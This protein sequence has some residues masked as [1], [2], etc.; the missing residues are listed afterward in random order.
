VSARDSDTHEEG[1]IISEGEDLG[2]VEADLKDL[3]TVK[4]LKFMSASF[5]FGE[6]K[7]TT[8]LIQE[9]EAVGY[10]PAGD[11]RAPLDEQVP[12]P[13]PD[14]VVVFRDF[15][16]CGLRF[17]CDPMLVDI[18][19]KFSV[20]IHQ[21]SPN[22]FL[23]LSKFFWIMR[24][25]RCNF[26]ADVFARLFEMVIEPRVIKLGDGQYRESHF[27]CCTFNTHRQNTRRRLT[28]I[29]IAPCCKTN[30]IKDW[31]SYWLYVKVDMSKI[32]GYEVPTF[33]LSSP[34]GEL[35]ATCTSSYN[36]RAVGFRNCESTFHL[37]SQIIGV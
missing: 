19:D 20:K 29:Q 27:G 13:A 36:H 34:I 3:V 4:Q 5:V 33:P 10:F 6:S 28:R 7:V 17:L 15:F 26:S 2:N 22:S 32:P 12:T 30:F 9:Y 24:T 23:E 11:G 8:N 16:V 37:A 35:T 25:F 21:L 1:E 14:E 31:N 18:L